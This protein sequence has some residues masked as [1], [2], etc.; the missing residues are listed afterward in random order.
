MR[1]TVKPNRQPTYASPSTSKLRLPQVCHVDQRITI[2]DRAA[3]HACG[4]RHTD[5]ITQTFLS[6]HD[7]RVFVI[8]AF[9][10]VSREMLISRASAPNCLAVHP[11]RQSVF[12]SLLPSI[13]PTVFLHVAAQPV[14]EFYPMRGACWN[15]KTCQARVL[16][17]EP[18][19]PTLKRCKS[20]ET[21]G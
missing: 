16:S 4:L 6:E 1:T 7:G 20:P 18:R 5:S 8:P 11:R 2:P 17:S 19:L 12:V 13:P 3:L 9:S 15:S 21:C 14:S 10:N